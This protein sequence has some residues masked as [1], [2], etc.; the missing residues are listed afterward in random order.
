MGFEKMDGLVLWGYEMAVNK[1]LCLLGY[2]HLFMYSM[3]STNRAQER[4]RL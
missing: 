1:R 2:R 3:E 4:K